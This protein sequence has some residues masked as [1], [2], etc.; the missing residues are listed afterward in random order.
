MQ[1]RSIVGA[2]IALVA[3]FAVAGSTLAFSGISN[4]SFETGSFTGAPWDTLHPGSTNITGWTIEVGSLDW[5]GG[6]WPA[7]DGSRS[8][9]LNGEEPATISQSLTAAVGNTYT[10]SFDLSSNP[11]CG[12]TIKTLTLGATGA[13]TEPFTYDP[14][15][16]GNTLIDM[17]WDTR[18]YVFVA[19]TTAPSLTFTSTTAGICGPALDNVV[20]TETVAPPSETQPTTLSDCKDEGWLT[21]VDGDGNHFKNQGDCVSYVATKHR[22]P[23]SCEAEEGCAKVTTSGRGDSR[24]HSAKATPTTS[25]RLSPT[26]PATRGIRPT[27]AQDRATTTGRGPKAPSGDVR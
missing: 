24:T 3:S 8:I 18:T 26:H 11:T 1:R 13:T 16:T 6:Y 17:K 5:I 21:V 23:G 10:V 2:A 20:I 15:V 22:N 7:S 27:D 14:S 25:H 19:M 12:P 9:D 4:G